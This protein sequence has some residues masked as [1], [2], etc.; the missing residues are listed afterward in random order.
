MFD[1]SGK[2]CL[3][4]EEL[5]A[6]RVLDTAFR[7]F[8]QSEGLQ[9]L[10]FRLHLL[11]I[12]RRERGYA[13]TYTVYRVSGTILFGKMMLRFRTRMYQDG[14]IRM[15]P[16]IVLS[17]PDYGRIGSLSTFAV[18]KLEGAWD[19]VTFYPLSDEPEKFFVSVSRF[20]QV[21]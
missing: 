12:T 5:G 19:E 4:D 16:V 3:R 1:N 14:V 21:V 18:S 13:N 10:R 2:S 15:S 11:D 20:G 17:I 6:A 7:N 9:H 8:A